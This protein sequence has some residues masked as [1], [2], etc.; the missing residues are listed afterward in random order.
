MQIKYISKISLK[1]MTCA[2]KDLFIGSNI[3]NANMEVCVK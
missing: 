2:V 3:F 1:M